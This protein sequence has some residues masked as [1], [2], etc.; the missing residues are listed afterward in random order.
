M[1]LDYD[2]AKSSAKGLATEMYKNVEFSGDEA[3]RLLKDLKNPSQPQQI[4]K[5]ERQ[6][7]EY[8]ELIQRRERASEENEENEY[9][10]LTTRFRAMGDFEN[11]AAFAEECNERYRTLKKSNDML[12]YGGLILQLGVTALYAVLLVFAIWGESFGWVILLCIIYPLALSIISYIMHKDIKYE[13]GLFL[14]MISV[15]VQSLF[16]AFVVAIEG[17]GGTITTALFFV[18]GLILTAIVLYIAGLPAC[19]IVW[20]R[21]GMLFD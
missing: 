8:S 10:E 7:R 6:R 12:R 14:W 11:A 17:G 16:V 15:I 2:S 21:A 5:E 13:A 9:N 18:G 20:K 1:S 19:F 3:R 4:T